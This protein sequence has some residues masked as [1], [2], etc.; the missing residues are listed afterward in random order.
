MVDYDPEWAT[1]AGRVCAAILRGG[2]ELVSGAQHIG[3]TAVP[4][5]PAKPILDIAVAIPAPEAMPAAVRRLAAS[6]Y[7]DRGDRGEDGGHLLVQDTP[8]GLR[9]IHLHVVVKACPQW[10]S[11]LRFRDL[12]RADV[13]LRRTY[14][15][16]KKLLARRYP[17]DRAAYTDAKGRFIQSVLR[18]DTTV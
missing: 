10:R 15:D 18:G 2:G 6:G 8:S 4:D 5:M 14:A 9:A 3:S 1:L 16:L 11:Y 7:I 13:T 17:E 12:L